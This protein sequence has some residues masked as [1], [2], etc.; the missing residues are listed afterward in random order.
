MISIQKDIIF[1]IFSLKFDFKEKW[2]LMLLGLA[3]ER[4][5]DIVFSNNEV[6]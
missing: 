4:Q 1:N 6:S 3:I 2:I 5:V